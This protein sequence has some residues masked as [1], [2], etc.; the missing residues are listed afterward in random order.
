M[1]EPAIGNK[2]HMKVVVERHVSV[3][4]RCTLAHKRYAQL[5]RS[6]DANEPMK[7]EKMME[8]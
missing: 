1:C 6:S 2:L 3:Q 5:D 4:N 8:E 7:R